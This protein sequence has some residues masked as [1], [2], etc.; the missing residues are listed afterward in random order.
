M[1]DEK[2]PIHIAVDLKGKMIE[3]AIEIKEK[4]GLQSW[5]EIMRYLVTQYYEE[6]IKNEEK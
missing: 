5:A 2:T 1:S 3:K 6:K 4:L